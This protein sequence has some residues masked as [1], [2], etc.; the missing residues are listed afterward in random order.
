[1]QR[2]LVVFLFLVGAGALSCVENGKCFESA[3][4]CCSGRDH[5]DSSCGE[6]SAGCSR[7]CETV[8]AIVVQKLNNSTCQEIRTQE[9]ADEGV[10]MGICDKLYEKTSYEDYNTCQ[11]LVAG[12]G[13]C[14]GKACALAAS[15]TSPQKICAESNACGTGKM[16]GCVPDGTCL[17]GDEE[18]SDCCNGHYSTTECRYGHQ[19]KGLMC[20]RS[21]VV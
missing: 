18:T 1:M 2:F 15:T 20:G 17:Q 10:D 16:C 9:G 14:L 13:V 5:G 7:V 4:T 12:S 3:S 6:G 8:M 21:V 11:G 19:R